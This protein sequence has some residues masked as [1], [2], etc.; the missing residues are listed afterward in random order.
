MEGAAGGGTL[1]P[2]AEALLDAVAE[3]RCSEAAAQVEAL[4][5]ATAKRRAELAAR[6]REQMLASM[7]FS[8]ASTQ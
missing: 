2:L 1:A 4:R 7:S 3:S 5:G 6:R 8:Q